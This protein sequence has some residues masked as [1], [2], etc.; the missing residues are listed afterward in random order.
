V[1]FYFFQVTLCEIAVGGQP[2]EGG[3]RSSRSEQLCNGEVNDKVASDVEGWHFG[4]ATVSGIETV[5]D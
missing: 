5:E 4:E 2:F 3:V 1:F